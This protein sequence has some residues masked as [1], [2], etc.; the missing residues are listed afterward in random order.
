MGGDGT[1]RRGRPPIPEAERKVGN[2]TFRTRG[3]LRAK[4]EVAAEESGRSVSEEIEH[5]LQVSFDQNAFALQVY[6]RVNPEI[7]QAILSVLNTSASAKIHPKPVVILAA[8][9]VLLAANGSNLQDLIKANADPSVWLYLSQLGISQACGLDADSAA[10]EAERVI[11]EMASQ[12]ADYRA[13][14]EMAVR[15]KKANA[16]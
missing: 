15:L 5:R 14:V 9:S 1:K 4:L 13:G 7:A 3:G 12:L 10:K 8:I 2:L 6:G 16:K 11:P